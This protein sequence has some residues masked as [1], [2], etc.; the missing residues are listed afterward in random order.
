VRRWPAIA[1]VLSLALIPVVARADSGVDP[2]AS[3]PAGAVYEIPLQ[4]ARQD[5]APHRHS[6]NGHA[7]GG[8]VGGTPGGGGS[9][10]G[11]TDPQ[12]S[13]IKSENGYGASSKVPGLSTAGAQEVSDHSPGSASAP[14]A[15]AATAGAARPTV[16]AANASAPATP[17]APSAGASF[18]LIILI[19]LG[20]V[21][22]G[23]VA[24]QAVRRALGGHP[25]T[26]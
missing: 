22:A 7:G 25:D 26:G 17:T 9:G 1:A 8:T 2:H 15:V 6:G 23:L 19:V 24:A 11:G 5:A 12:G 21:A 16:A 10:G 4:T 20:G 13:E 18:G 14:K 3:S